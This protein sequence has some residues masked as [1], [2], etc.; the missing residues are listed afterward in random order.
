MFKIIQVK[1]TL[2]ITRTLKVLFKKLS[3]R[4][5]SSHQFSSIKAT[6]LCRDSKIEGNYTS[7]NISNK[8]I[9]IIEY[10]R[11]EGEQMHQSN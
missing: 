3:L 2:T 9:G 10:F 4:S 1:P 5:S 11:R 8:K 7:Q 6:I